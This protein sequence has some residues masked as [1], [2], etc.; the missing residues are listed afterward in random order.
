MNQQDSG[1]GRLS[2]TKRQDT[3]GE[4]GR[5]IKRRQCRDFEREMGMDSDRERRGKE[6]VE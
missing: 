3:N 5:G 2:S 6:I 1:T 4:R